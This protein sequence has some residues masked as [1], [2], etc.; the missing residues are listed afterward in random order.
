[1]QWLNPAGAWAFALLLPVVALYL[2]KKRAKRKDVPSLLLWR[3]TEARSESSRPFQR[4]K[5]QLLLWLQLAAV[6]LLAVALMRPAAMGG[7]RGETA[8]IFDLSAS[9][10]TTADG[11][12]RLDEAKAAAYRILDEMGDNDGVTIIAAGSELQQPLSRSADHGLARSIIE[13][14]EAENGTADVAGA[15][16]LA[17]AMGRELNGLSVVVLSDTYTNPAEGVSVLSVGEAMPNRSIRSLRL[18]EQDEGM[19]AFAQ[20]TSLGQSVEAELECYG[21][22]TLCDMRTV[23]IDDGGVASV[24]FIVPAGV[25]TV[26]VRFAQQDALPADDLRYAVRPVQ[27]Q[28]RALLITEGNVFLE[29]ALSLDGSLTVTRASL[30]DAQS[31]EGYDLY[32]YDGLLPETLPQSGALMV[33]DPQSELLGITP[34]ESKSPDGVLRAGTGGVAQTVCQH[35]LLG[36]IAVKAYRPLTGGES[37]LTMGGDTL[38][39][40][41]ETAGR[42]YAVLGFDLHESNLPLKADFP[43]LVQNLL[44]YLLPQSAVSVTDGVCGRRLTLALN[45]RTQRAEVVLPSGRRAAVENGILT[46]TMELGL[47][48]LLEEQPDGAV[49]QTAFALHTPME[50][51]DTMTVA[52]SVEGTGGA[53]GESGTGREYAGWLLLLALAL[54]IAEWEVSRRGA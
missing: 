29:K 30:E 35:L 6:V 45:D 26:M 21:D 15:V 5:S 8:L 10:Q 23:E 7:L 2:L 41:G 4:L 32:L 37:V 43:V 19:I 28:R 46:D 54:L 51:S 9:M 14:L 27:T 3:I 36:D 22:G 24:R 42:R 33:I 20:V 53:A 13:K 12:T 49:R 31:A 50:E 52:D 25:N 38:L 44:G 34:G 48:T 18:S 47:Y 1:M 17:Q 11:G 16:A 40:A 39:A